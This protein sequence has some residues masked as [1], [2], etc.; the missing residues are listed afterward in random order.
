MLLCH[1][2]GQAKFSTS[3]EPTST[4]IGHYALYNVFRFI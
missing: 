4:L 1:D 2:F 3:F